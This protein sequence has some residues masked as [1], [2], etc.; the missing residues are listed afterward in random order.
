M[1]IRSLKL[2]L[3]VLLIAAALAA[4]GCGGSDDPEPSDG[5]GDGAGD[6]APPPAA[7]DNVD[8]TA[9]TIVPTP[10][11]SAFD[12]TNTFSLPAFVE[13]VGTDLE[14]WSAEPAS[15]V[16][17]AG[18]TSD[19]GSQ[20]GVL[21]TV[22]ENVPE[23]EI[24]VALGAIGGK[25]TL[26]ISSVTP[27]QTAA[28]RDRYTM[29]EAFDLDAFIAGMISAGFGGGGG[30]PAMTEIPDNLR[31]DTCHTE[32]AENLGV[33]N[34]PTQTS[35]YSDEEL[36]A[37]FLTGTKPAGVGFRVLPTMVQSFYGEFHAWRATDAEIDGL[38]AYLRS[39]EPKG[40]GMIRP[41][42][43]E[44]A[45][46]NALPPECDPQSAADFDADACR[47]AL[48]L[49]PAGMPPAA[50]PTTPPAADAGMAADAGI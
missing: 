32:G 22:V 12:G 5:A 50:P 33:Q 3:W 30:M 42:N 14:N 6:G 18:W 27:E 20:Q 21:I 45:I 13:N 28:G 49:P 4:V 11:H 29:G 10:M 17:L 47:E 7:T 25:S 41:P 2:D 26:K 8:Y 37:I 48:G 40:Q 43:I 46:A 9:L 38:I 31:C 35:L 36:K 15:A 19:D 39:L 23:I 34:T 44:D 16:S 24:S 1:S